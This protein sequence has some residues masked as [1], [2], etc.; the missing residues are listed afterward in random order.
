MDQRAESTERVRE[1]TSTLVGGAIGEIFAAGG[2]IGALMQTLDWAATPIGNPSEWPQSLRTA[3]SICLMS[4]FPL[5]VWW[6]PELVMLYND[7]YRELIAAKHPRA[8]GASAP[9]VFPEIWDIIGPMLEGVLRRGSAT[10][11][12]DQQILL[13]RHGYLEE[14]Y[15]TYAF[16]PIYGESGGVEG[17]FTAISETTGRVLSERRMRALRELAAE[18]GDARSMEDA[19]AR[20]LRVLS[21]HSADLPFALLYLF[22]DDGAHLRRAGAPGL[23]EAALEAL[24]DAPTIH[25]VV[26]GVDGDARPPDGRAEPQTIAHAVALAATTNRSVRVELLPE[27]LLSLDGWADTP[28][29]EAL[30][31]PVAQAGQERPYGVLVA[32]VNPLRALDDDYRGFFDLVAGQLATSLASVRAYEAERRRAEALAEL[33]RAKTAFFSNVSHEF[34]TPLTLLLGPLA[35]A[36]ADTDEPLPAGQRERLLVIQRNGLRLLKLVNSL[37]DFSRIE[38]GRAQASYAPVDLASLTTDLASSFRSLIE[39]AG[40]R[41][42]VDCPPLVGL[43]APLYVDRDLWEKIVLNLLSNAFKF[44]FAGEIA[45]SLRV[46]EDGAAAQLTVR[47]TGTGIAP[48]EQARIFERFHRVEGARSRTFEGSGIGLALVRELAL[49]HGG[50]VGVESAVGEGTTFTVRIPVG[51]AHLPAERVR[52]ERASSSA[53]LGVL[54]FVEEAAR[55]LPVAADSAAEA[56]ARDGTPGDRAAGRA[57]AGANETRPRVL[58]ADD[59]ADMRDYTARLLGRRYSVV[60][61]PD[62]QAALEEVRARGA[63][64]VLTD[65]MMPRLDGFGL[66]RALK[67]DPATANIPV[68]VLSARAGEEATAEGL[69]RGADDYLIKPFAERE[70]L[71]RVEARLEVARLRG[72]AVARAREL[73]TMFEAIT[74]ALFI[75]DRD[76]RIVRMNPA[77]RTLFGLD[78]IPDY[79]EQSPERRAA[80][81]SARDE[82][83]RPIPAKDWGLYRL[84]KG[85]VL[86][87]ADALDVRLR[88]ADGRELEVSITGAPLTDE[89]GAITGAI[90]VSRDVTERRRLERRT[91]EALDALVALTEDV[92]RVPPLTQQSSGA[93]NE[94]GDRL[95]ALVRRVFDCDMVVMSTLDPV[96]GAMRPLAAVGLDPEVEARW[97][98][99]VAHIPLHNYL[100]PDTLARIYAREPVEI[101]LDAEP[102]CNGADHK[103]HRI[104]MSPL[105]LGETVVGLM[106]AEHR[107][108]P[109][110]Y[111]E[112]DLALMMAMGRLSALAIERDRLL[113][114]Q[115]ESKLRELALLETNRRMDEFLGIAGHELRTPL[116]SITATV[117]MSERQVGRLAQAARANG[118]AQAGVAERSQEL[119]ARTD[120][121]LK[122]LNR[123][124]TDLLDVSRI[125]AGHLEMRIEPADLCEVVRDAVEAQRAGWPERRITLDLPRHGPLEVSI[126]ADRIGQVVDNYLTNALKYSADHAPVAVRLRLRDGV[127][128]VEVRDRGPGLSTE[129]LPHIWERFHRVPGIPQRSGS[130]VGLGL[131]LYISREIIERHGGAVGVESTPGEGSTFWFTLPVGART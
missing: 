70:L 127:A 126:D 97:W 17:V 15:F 130:G 58:V 95:V 124:V 50:E 79:A 96:T 123:L 10:W 111:T 2:E 40:L 61:A 48:Q 3:V 57:P 94:I 72:E 47:D 45:I 99:D 5:L 109:R 53:E 19:V 120:R 77:A 104:L 78:A 128:R 74:D 65:V 75:Y 35:D 69:E 55:W 115:S 102:L 9:E 131:G 18:T 103:V 80:V 106:S 36:L 114:E 118:D 89:A 38:E 100:T 8:M 93:V 7:A 73:D 21:V 119:L 129:Q 110:P 42:V 98:R 52:S 37:L 14:C 43:S 101:D 23:S 125:S 24:G 113:R 20:A 32:G 54:P 83:G 59:N 90:A 41:Y 87:G 33:D 84:L 68:I 92:V 12:Y 62:G 117:Q 49:L 11:S 63:D 64:L 29:H 30:G 85:E 39:R 28:P 121:Q 116:T 44:T 56:Q 86:T 4:R 31:I 22:D 76:G 6:G 88:F 66:V 60:V 34:R 82:E 81:V 67:A 112:D 108:A 107:H 122:R 1:T 91:Q 71:A 25:A 46:V 26:S 105:V 51:A 16:S 27:R 13:D